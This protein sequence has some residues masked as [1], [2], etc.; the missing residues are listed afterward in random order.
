MNQRGSRRGAGAPT[1]QTEHDGSESEKQY[2]LPAPVVLRA[3]QQR[4]GQAC[5][6]NP[7]G[8]SEVVDELGLQESAKDQLLGQRS[9]RNGEEAHQQDGDAILQ[10]TLDR[11][12]DVGCPEEFSQY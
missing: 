6:Q 8:W 10:Q 9:E 5:C 4:E 11:V 12:V 1:G 3:M 2:V 7:D